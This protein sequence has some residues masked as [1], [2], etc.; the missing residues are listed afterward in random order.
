MFI[1]MQVA[2]TIRLKVNV[3][4]LITTLLQLCC[5]IA[6]GNITFPEL[7]ELL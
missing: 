5:T 2:A 1:I 3:V 7:L 6:N 4:T